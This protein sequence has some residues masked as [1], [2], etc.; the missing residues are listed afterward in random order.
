[1]PQPLREP[2]ELGYIGKRDGQ[3]RA[4]FKVRDSGRELRFEGPYRDS[5]ELAHDDRLTIRAAASKTMTRTDALQA[6]ELQAEHL[7]KEAKAEEG[8]LQAADAQYRARVRYIDSSG[9]RRATLGPVRHTER[10]A[11]AD[12]ESMRKEA[13]GKSMRADHHEAM[14][15][16]AHR[17][18]QH[19]AYEVQV[20]IGS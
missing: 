12:L 4:E 10:R 1:M 7:K 5:E 13:A 16:A 14:S 15:K 17:L 11:Q 9:K 3:S 19:A 8:G 18:Q 6:M 20:A 2:T